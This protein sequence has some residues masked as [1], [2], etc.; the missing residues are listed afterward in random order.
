M[1]IHIFIFLLAKVGGGGGG[2]GW[3]V[4]E[5]H[6]LDPPMLRWTILD[7]KWSIDSPECKVTVLIIAK[8]L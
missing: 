4:P 8:F 2:G 1:H 6:P 3:H 5:M 7:V